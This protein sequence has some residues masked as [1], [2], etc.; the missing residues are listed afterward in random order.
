MQETK[1]WA[2]A[3]GKKLKAFLKSQGV[4]LPH[5]QCLEAVAAMH[6]SKNW[7]TF[8][9]SADA[10]IEVRDETALHALAETALQAVMFE[11]LPEGQTLST[12]KNSLMEAAAAEE[13][14]EEWQP[15]KHRMNAIWEGVEERDLMV[16]PCNLP[17][18]IDKALA[19]VHTALRAKLLDDKSESGVI[20]VLVHRMV[21]WR[22]ADGEGDNMPETDR[23]TYALSV[24]VVG[25]HV[26]ANLAYPHSK[27]QSLDIRSPQ[28]GIGMYIN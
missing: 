10:D 4:E 5:K 27:P 2:R 28:L 3:Q 14:G 26:Q 13:A 9:A 20:P 6:G 7:Q 17:P 21:D 24:N 18:V 15:Q 25:T 23:R 1:A 19:A 8:E 22:V 11:A 12:L 16:P